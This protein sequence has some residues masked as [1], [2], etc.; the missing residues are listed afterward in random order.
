MRV[1]FSK[2]WAMGKLLICT[3]VKVVTKLVCV[4]VVGC[5][6][7]FHA[8]DWAADRLCEVADWAADRYLE[9]GNGFSNRYQGDS[10]G[11]GF[12]AS[13]YQGEGNELQHV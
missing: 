7:T 5:G 13:R 9:E 4:G 1:V 11:N 6:L 12:S 2:C 3:P 8:L 10:E